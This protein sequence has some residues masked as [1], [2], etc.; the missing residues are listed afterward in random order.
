MSNK[1]S[2]IGPL[3]IRKTRTKPKFSR[4]NKTIKI[5]TEI[6]ET[7]TRITTER[8]NEI[9]SCIFKDEQNLD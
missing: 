7:E 5:G 1:Q 4:G 3:R 2:N 6:K 8:I 9:K